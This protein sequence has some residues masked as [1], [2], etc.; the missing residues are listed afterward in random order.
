V[1]SPVFAPESRF[2]QRLADQKRNQSRH[3]KSSR[4]ALPPW[5]AFALP[6]IAPT[7]E[8]RPWI[9]LQLQ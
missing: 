3:V 9:T 2:R 4:G 5:A 8:S 7:P 6:A 1:A